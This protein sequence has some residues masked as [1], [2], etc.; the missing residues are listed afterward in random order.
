[1]RRANFGNSDLFYANLSQAICDDCLLTTT[2]CT[3]AIF[4]NAG[5]SNASFCNA[6]LK[7]ADFSGA[8]LR[9]T[10]FEGSD[11][12]EAS[13]KEAD[14]RGANFTRATLVQTDLS[15]AD[16]SNSLIHGI[17]AYN[18][19]LEG[20]RQENLIITPSDEPVISVD[21]FASAQ[22]VYLLLE[23]K[24]VCDI[25]DAAIERGVLLLGRFSDGGLELLQAVAAKLREM[26]Y[27][28][29]IFNLDKQNS[30]ISL[31]TIRTLVGLS[32]FVIVDL[33]GSSVPRELYAI[34]P[35]F[36]RPFV[37]IMQKREETSPMF[38]ALLEY[39]WVLSP[40]RF[41]NKEQLIEFLPSNVVAS[42]E[43]KLKESNENTN[44][45]LPSVQHMR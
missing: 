40:I 7:Y 25:F 5:L 30:Q 9:E 37:P 39:S 15:H 28:P 34:I 21:N 14:L 32:R 41:V 24:K 2:R 19:A 3:F 20:A 31:K 6:S 16:L 44:S 10:N 43:G 8:T 26:R 42:A 23:H 11:L 22:Y 4:R 1:L 45:R 18:V 33:S 27:L 38:T 36:R 17:S 13:F 35:Y 29:M 12:R